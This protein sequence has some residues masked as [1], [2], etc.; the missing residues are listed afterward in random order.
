M[1]LGAHNLH[2]VEESQQVF[3][4]ESYHMHPEYNKYSVSNDILLVKV[5]YSLWAL[6][7]AVSGK[8]E[9]QVLPQS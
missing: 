1:V 9:T 6:P 8:A 3:G 4:V 2:K 5:M 7:R